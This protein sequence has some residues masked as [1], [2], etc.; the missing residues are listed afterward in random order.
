MLDCWCFFC[1]LWCNL[2]RFLRFLQKTTWILQSRERE[3]RIMEWIISRAAVDLG[4]PHHSL[5]DTTITLVR[6]DNVLIQPGT[7][8]LEK[9]YTSLKNIFNK[10][11]NTRI[12]QLKHVY[13]NLTLKRSYDCCCGSSVLWWFYVFLLAVRDSVTKTSEWSAQDGLHCFR[14]SGN[15]LP[16]Q[17]D[18]GQM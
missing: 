18:L 8:S 3:R 15:P 2:Q 5:L 16:R 6:Y 12:F 7:Q 4:S 11:N 13:L 9:H 1:N 10:I 17:L 14:K